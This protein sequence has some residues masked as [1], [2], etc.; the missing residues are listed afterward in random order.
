MATLERLV[1]DPQ[2]GLPANVG[3]HQQK[4]P[5]YLD[6]PPRDAHRRGRQAGSVEPGGRQGH[7]RTADGRL[8]LGAAVRDLGCHGRARVQPHAGAA[9]HDRQP[10]RGPAA[11]A[12]GRC[13]STRSKE[14][15]DVP[16]HDAVVRAL[17]ARHARRRAQA[18]QG[19]RDDG[20]VLAGGQ[21][22][23]DWFKDRAK[24]PA[25]RDRPH[26]HR[27]AQGHSRDR[28]G[29]RDRRA[30]HA[31][32]DRAQRRLVLGE[33]RPAGRGRGPRRQ[34]ADPQRRHARRQSLPG[35]AL[36]VLP[37]RR[38][39][40]PRRRQHLLRGHAAGA[41]PRTLPV[42]RRALH[43]RVAVGLRAGG[44]GARGVAS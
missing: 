7:R 15:N 34:S 11:A 14:P 37:L 39:L 44:G 1:F 26:R 43:R 3:L 16:R 28:R 20:W 40:L 36:L 22:S 31:H 10:L 5:S 35:R 8:G 19:P 6:L 38:R 9:R 2:N 27:R 42:R 25:A 21:D 41:E 24:R 4:P 29:T 33:V 30:D 23:Y 13:P 18:G 17:P 32:R 12:Q